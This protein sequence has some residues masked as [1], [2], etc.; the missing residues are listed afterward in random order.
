MKRSVAS[1]TIACNNARQLPRQLDTLLSQTRPLE[2]II[3]ADNAS[4]DGTWELLATEY[5]RVTVLRMAENRGAAGAWSAGL[6]YAAFQKR[7]DWIWAFDADSVPENTA[8]ECLL[9]GAE[10]ALSTEQQSPSQGQPAPI[11]MLAMLLV[12]SKRGSCY[13][14]LLW[15]DGFVKPSATMLAQPV[16]F[17]DLTY[18]SGLMV[19]RKLVEAVGLPRA[20]FFMDFFDF[21]YC[22]RARAHGYRIAVVTGAKLAHEIGE[23]REVRLPGF[24]ALWP[25]HAP[26]REY[27]MS[28]NLTYALWWLYPSTLGRRFALGHLLR[29]AG[30]VLLFGRHKAACLRKMALGFWDGRR[31]RLGVRFRPQEESQ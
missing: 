22:L 29:H 26:W 18:T 16:W 27:Y 4:T 21:E 1:I 20:D 28:R 7:H 14:P 25:D 8:L 10:F 11:G 2:E 5:P 19:S 30:G 13:P 31:G 6:E 3:V 17:A 24:S 15:R 12:N 9:A 23:A